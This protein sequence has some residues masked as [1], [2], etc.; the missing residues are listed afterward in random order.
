L[1]A[2]AD[3]IS[4]SGPLPS[5][6]GPSALSS[7]QILQQP[8]I[9]PF[10]GPDRGCVQFSLYTPQSSLNWSF[11]F[12][13]PGASGGPPPPPQTLSAPL[14]SADP[15]Q[16]SGFFATFDPLDPSAVGPRNTLVFLGTNY[17]G[18]TTT[19]NSYY[20]T[21]VGGTAIT[22]TPVIAPGAAG[23]IPAKL[24]FA[25]PPT[26]ISVA[27]YLALQPSGDFVIGLSGGATSAQVLCGLQGAEYL[28]VQANNRIRFVSGQPAFVPTFPFPISSPVAPPFDPTV[29]PLTSAWTTSWALVRPPGGAPASV[30]AVTQPPG[31]NLFGQDQTINAH[32][33]NLLGHADP[34]TLLPADPQQPFPLV[35]YTGV[36]PSANGTTF[37]P[38]QVVD[39]EAQVLGPARHAAIVVN[40]QDSLRV[41]SAQHRVQRTRALTVGST[42]CPAGSTQ[43]NVTTPSGY[44]VTLCETDTATTWAQILLAKLLGP[45][46]QPEQDL[47][48]VAPDAT[49]EQAFQTGQ[50]M[51]VIANAQHTGNFE[52]ELTIGEWGMSA[53]V[54]AG[55]SYGDYA[56]IVIVKGLPGALYDPSASDPTTNL[57]GNPSKWTMAGDFAAPS[58][59]GAP[60]ATQLPNLALWLQDYFAAAFTEN[61]A[62]PTYF[63]SFCALAQDPNWTGVLV[64][65]GTISDVP[66]GLAG[67]TAGVT[68]PALFNVHHLAVPL[69][70][71][72][73]TSS[74][75][76]VLQSSAVSGLIYYLDPSAA[77]ANPSA[78]LPTDPSA[79]YAFR[80]LSLKVL[81]E[82]SALKA[83]SS[84]VQITMRSLFGSTASSPSTFDSIV[85]SGSYQ[86]VDGQPIYSMASVADSP[87][88]L[89]NDVLQRVEVTGVQMNT[90]S[91]NPTGNTVSAFTLVGYL[92]F[93]VVP[94][95]DYGSADPKNPQS[96]DLYGFGNAPGAS[97]PRQGLA[98]Q[99]LTL[100]MSFAT[101]A[102]VPQTF[103][104]QTDPMRFDLGNST[105]R[106]ASLVNEFNLQLTSYA[107]Y[108]AN[109]KTPPS[110]GFLPVVAMIP[111]GD[112]SSGWNGL[113]FQ[114]DLGTPGELASKAG[115]T[116]SM[117]L[118]WSPSTGEGP[119]VQVG[120]QLPG[121]AQGAPL[122]SLQ[123]VLKLSIGQVALS[124]TATADKS[125]YGFLLLLNEIAMIFLGL[126]KIPPNGATSFYLFGDPN[127][128]N[129][130][131]WY[132][133]YN[134][135]PA[136]TPLALAKR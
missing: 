59:G 38:A 75:P 40:E 91:T 35:P 66:E 5:F 30:V 112:L 27:Q 1:T 130:L 108:D 72:T 11:L 60:D 9:L 117:L 135:E 103:T 131:G 7:G 28:V 24:V 125:R 124:Y 104:L 128:A 129:A 114:V 36:T 99:A 96:I 34:G 90:V 98:F 118:A 97:L 69:T 77:P 33:P 82:S 13:S 26:P 81:F 107:A 132:A 22:L 67:I 18:S 25:Y 92:D 56:N 94:G 80:L 79:P 89:A 63:S 123:N 83:F 134:N 41:L 19:L 44:L 88:A 120:L 21:A 2:S 116:S 85:L 100:Q 62:D 37:T 110:L 106:P 95:V 51:L 6:S 3:A 10:S 16:I 74:G 8:L 53:D 76:Q 136:A 49:L 55:Q 4:I 122:I 12:G 52:N 109:G 68:D 84:Y 50:L 126:L 119:Q 70:P 14:A 48:F 111:A 23:D 47:A 64:L 15:K 121:T 102:P 73:N 65:R 61:A 115:L 78:P 133:I 71:I 113:T 31:F 57:V 101:Q 32:Y 29:S 39:F 87:F 43:V 58:V 45:P 46:E 54:G 105:L 20:T 42:M 93:A 17:N 127:G 86:M